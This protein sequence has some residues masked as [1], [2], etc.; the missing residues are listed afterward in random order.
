MSHRVHRPYSEIRRVGLSWDERWKCCDKGLINCWEIGRERREKDPELSQRAE[1][2]E[3]PPLEWKGGV[4]RP[5]KIQVKYG[6][7]NYLA[8]WQGLRGEDLDIDL[9]S[10]VE[11]TCSRTGMRVIFTG[12]AHK[13]GKE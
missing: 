12:D 7:L 3:L 10:E 11:L 9:S 4:V 5:L 2:G 13:Y 1:N 8:A 6:T